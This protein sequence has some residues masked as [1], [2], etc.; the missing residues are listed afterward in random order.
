M[1]LR[2]VSKTIGRIHS[3]V[4]RTNEAQC[5]AKIAASLYRISEPTANIQA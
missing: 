2:T 1:I 4:E 5:A 3:R